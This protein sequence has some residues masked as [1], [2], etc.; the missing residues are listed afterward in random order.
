MIRFLFSY[1]MSFFTSC[2]GFLLLVFYMQACAYVD[3]NGVLV[4]PFG[5]LV[6]F[7]F[8]QALSFFILV[9]RLLFLNR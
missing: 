3:T 8:M 4:E 5:L 2:I 6:L 9:V 1:P 7:W